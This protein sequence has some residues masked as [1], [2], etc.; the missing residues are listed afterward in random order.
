MLVTLRVAFNGTLIAL[1]TLVH[2]TPLLLL[3]LIKLIVPIPSFRQFISAILAAIAESWIA[4]NSALIRLLTGLHVDV[5][6]LPSLRRNGRYLLICNH[7]SVADIPVVQG[8]LNRRIPLLRFFLKQELIWVPVLGLA[9]W[10][11]DFPFMHRTTKSQLA[12]NPALAGKDRHATR[13][14]CEKFRHTPVSIINFVEGTRFTAAKHSSRKSPYAHL[15]APRSGGIAYVVEAMGD[16]L[17]G[18]IDVSLFYPGG[19]PGAV[20]LFAG[21]V[22][23]VAMKVELLSLPANLRGGDYAGDAECRKAFQA[24]LNERW[25]LKD[26]WIDSRARSQVDSGADSRAGRP[27]A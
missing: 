4:V 2:A 6:E 13:A 25:Q 20:D 15:L 16:V 7:Q 12:T 19:I 17:D 27:G 8:V 21:K 18:V 14:A 9:W 3:A 11:L 1:N 22:K 10:A 26:A 24:W 5:N 23:R